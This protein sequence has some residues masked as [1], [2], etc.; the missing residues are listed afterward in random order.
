MKSVTDAGKVA[1]AAVVKGSTEVVEPIQGP[2]LDEPLATN[3]VEA[4]RLARHQI[5]LS[6]GHLVGVTVA[7]RGVPLVVVHGFSVEGF[8]YAQSLSRLVKMGFRVIAID[9][10]GHGATQGLPLS[11]QNLN[12]YADLLARAVDELGLERF[13]LAGHS[14]GGQ[15]ITRMA[16]KHPDR[17]MGVVLIDA[18]VGD[19]WDR[20]VY[21]FRVAPPLLG[22]VGGVLLIDSLSIMPTFSDPRQAAKLIRLVA[23]TLAGHMV[24]PWRLLGPM[25]SI[26]RTRSSR[27]ALDEIAAHDI[28]VFVLHG[29]MDLA[30]PHRTARDTVKRTD[31]VLVTIEGAGHSWMLR[32]PEALP[33]IVAELLAAEL[34]DGIRRSLRAAGVRKKHPTLEDVEAV[35]YRPDAKVFALSPGDPRRIRVGRHRKPKYSWHV[36]HA[37]S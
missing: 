17:V 5:E 33:A 14:M 26:L 28:P 6:D 9:T 31:G 12:D 16:A 3:S 36:E 22:A 23:P 2:V 1:T 15:L 30:V 27:Y 7:G 18:I 24:Q 32:D 13:V 10:A 19:T 4:P 11:G 25:L 34:G 20:M 35:C 29:S 8:L 21:L 37:S